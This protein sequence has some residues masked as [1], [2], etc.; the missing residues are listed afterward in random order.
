[1]NNVFSSLPEVQAFME[2]IRDRKQELSVVLVGSAARS[3]HNENSDID[4]LAISRE[5]LVD[6]IIPRRVHLMRSTYDTFLR[7][8]EAGED[9][10]AW[11]VRLGVLIHDNGLWSEVLARPEAN[12]WPSW[13]KKVLH[14]TR[15]LLFASNLLK[16]GDLDA[17]REELL[18]AVGH[19]ARGLLLKANIFPLSRP[20][21][22]KQVG[23]I[24]YTDLAAIH[25]RLRTDPNYGLH[26]LRRCQKY[27]KKLLLH[28]S[29]QDYKAYSQK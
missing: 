27:S 29:A 1:M 6:V 5:P 22:E 14:G 10:E 8:L 17:A 23:E 9:F 28:L 21:L 13:E 18:Y 20:E 2:G 26:L 7:Q 3:T 25:E 4:L 15:R 19:V 24:G 16:T 12:V 11:C